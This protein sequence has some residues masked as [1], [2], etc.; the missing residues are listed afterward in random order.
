M[1]SENG[2]L[3]IIVSCEAGGAQ[4]LSSWIRDV[5]PNNNYIYCLQ[6]P[7]R[8]IFRKKL[9]KINEV[10][11]D[12][13]DSMNASFDRIMTSTSWLPDLERYAI[14]LAREKSIYSIS[15]L[16]HWTNYR[17]R[18]L[19][20][21]LWNLIPNNWF[22]YLPDEIWVCDHYAFAIAKKLGFP[23]EK[24][25]QIENPYLSYLKHELDKKKQHESVLNDRIHVLY[26]SEPIADDLRKTYGDENYWGYTEYDMM[27][28]LIK[29]VNLLKKRCMAVTWRIRL[30]PNE[31]EGKY[32]LLTNGNPNIQVTKNNDLLEDLN[33]ADAIVGG[34]SM[35][36]VIALETEK[37]VFSITFESQRKH[38]TLPH[39]KIR[40]IK[41]YREAVECLIQTT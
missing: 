2:K 33:W 13:L 24:L 18:F 32:Q 25:F 23:E 3:T 39:E 29:D 10:E 15:I 4:I 21:R 20:V 34:E 22:S 30:H 1:K 11:L 27:K 6:E 38:F 17:E 40:K 41:N 14:A 16:D 36:L 35:A 19:P 26:L 8:S 9:G 12:S 31:H 5:L 37:P 7:A 28:A